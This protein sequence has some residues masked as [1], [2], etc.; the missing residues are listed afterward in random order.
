M[1]VRPEEWES[2]LDGID[3]RPTDSQLELFFK[4]AVQGYRG[5]EYDIADY[6]RRRNPDG[7]QFR[8]YEY[9]RCMVE[10]RIQAEREQRNNSSLLEI[11]RSNPALNPALAA[12][13]DGAATKARESGGRRGRS[14]PDGA[15]SA[16]GTTARDR[17]TSQGSRRSVATTASAYPSTRRCPRWGTRMGPCLKGDK[18]PHR[19]DVT[20]KNRIRCPAFDKGVCAYEDACKFSHGDTPEE[21]ARQAKV[22]AKH[23]LAAAGSTAKEEVRPQSPRTESGTGGTARVRTPSPATAN[24]A[25]WGSRDG[26][27]RDTTSPPA[28]AAVAPD[29]N[30]AGRS[31]HPELELNNTLA[32]L[33]EHVRAG[34]SVPSDVLESLRRFS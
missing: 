26:T 7:S 10:R 28:M 22:D 29:A 32:V 2:I 15:N 17:S 18:C 27:P 24:Q 3:E 31:Q 11:Q 5:L 34:G 14:G 9:L 16:A 21:L 20:V 23:Q 4:E 25:A 13:T 8:C 19:H 30:T 1:G 6:N 33:R 12:V